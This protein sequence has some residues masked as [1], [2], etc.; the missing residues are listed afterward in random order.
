M[1]KFFEETLKARRAVLQPKAWDIAEADEVAAPAAVAP[2]VPIDPAA[3]RLAK[4]RKIEIPSRSLLHGQFGDS[5]SLRHAEESYL[6]LRTRLLKLRSSQGI[7]SLVVT[8][9]VPGEGKT[10]TSLNLAHYCA[11]LHDM[12]ILLIDGDL[13][14]CGLSQALGINSSSGLAEVLSG[15]YKPEDVIL[16]TDNPN[17][18]VV[19]S[20]A[21]SGA[22]AELFASSRWQEFITWCNQSFMLTIVDSPPVLNLSDVELITVPC[23]G[24]LMVVRALKTKREILQKCAGQL[25]SKK[26][27]G[28]VFNAMHEASILRYQ[29]GYY[30]RGRKRQ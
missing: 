23:E 13:R 17:L 9:S 4:C 3:A 18:H 16:A 28:V 2:A 24:V 29:Y 30:D 8:S 14:N 19:S 6:G 15:Q 20:G 22:P 21:A 1:S 5:E 7:R 11:Q 27:L 25:D 26:L 12:R 10:H